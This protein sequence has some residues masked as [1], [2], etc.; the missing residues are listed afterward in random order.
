MNLQ[1]VEPSQNKEE[2]LQK[3]IQDFFL[4]EQ[5]AFT[6]IT[7]AFAAL[8]DLW[9]QIEKLP[10]N[11]K[12]MLNPLVLQVHENLSAVRS[13]LVEQFELQLKILEASIEVESSKAVLPSDADINQEQSP[14]PVAIDESK[15]DS[16]D[17]DISS[18]YLLDI[19][20]S[21]KPYKH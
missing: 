14:N 1:I 10:T 7:L 6:S 9:A 19:D 21:K 4:K 20:N 15:S 3:D 13:N 16:K 5:P 2:Q 8:T 17:L 12:Q 11:Q 18:N